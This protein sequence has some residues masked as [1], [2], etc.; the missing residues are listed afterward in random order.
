MRSCYSVAFIVVLVAI[1]VGAGGC[2]KDFD[3]R[4]TALSATQIAG[5]IGYGTVLA[6]K[7]TEPGVTPE[8]AEQAMSAYARFN[9]AIGQGHAA[10]TADDNPAFQEAIVQAG[11]ELATIMQ[12]SAATCP[13]I[14]EGG[15]F[16]KD[17]DKDE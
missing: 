12:I 5:T 7:L 13:V 1:I 16:N 14:N 6:H 4:K 8:Q 10:I 2:G 3:A 17:K 9:I 11:M 15:S